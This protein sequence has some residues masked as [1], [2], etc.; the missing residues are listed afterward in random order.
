MWRKCSLA[1]EGV[2]RNA[3]GINIHFHIVCAKNWSNSR[4]TP[5]RIGAPSGNPGSA[6]GATWGKIFYRELKK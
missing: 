6:T 5:L 3:P 4:L 1:D 2:A